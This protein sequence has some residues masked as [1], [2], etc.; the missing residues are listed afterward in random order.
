MKKFNVVLPEVYHQ[1][2]KEVDGINIVEMKQKNVD[3]F[4]TP[5]IERLTKEGGYVKAL[6]VLPNLLSQISKE[7]LN[8]V[9]LFIV[10]NMND[11]EELAQQYHISKKNIYLLAK[12]DLI[13]MQNIVLSIRQRFIERLYDFSYARDKGKWSIHPKVKVS[14]LGDKTHLESSLTQKEI[15]YITYE[16]VEDTHIPLKPEQYYR[17]AVRGRILDAI[18]V[19]IF[20]VTY[21][22]GVKK[23]TYSLE[24]NTDQYIHLS[25][26]VEYG[27]VMIRVQGAGQAYIRNV[28][29][30]AIE[31]NES[32]PKKKNQYLLLT[33]AYASE[34]NLYKNAFIHRR[35]KQYQQEGIELDLFVLNNKNGLVE[36]E[37]DGVKVLQG[38]KEILKNLLSEMK[39]TKI[40]IHF[41]N[42]EMLEAIK[43][44]KI[45]SRLIV[46]IHGFG[47]ERYQ[48]RLYNYS[49]KELLEKR[50]ELEKRDEIQMKV[51]KQ[52]Y[53]SSSVTNIFVSEFIKEIAQQDAGAK[54]K[55]AV[56]I[57]NIID[58]ELFSYKKKPVHQRK[59]ILFIRPFVSHN[60]ACDLAVQVIMELSKRECFNDLSF[61]IYGNGPL[62][63][64]L[65]E[66]LKAFN[67]VSLNP[68]FVKQ[69]EIAMLHK[70]HGI[71]LIPTRHDTQG[72][73]MG[74]AMS[75]GLVVA[76]NK[77]C[78]IP[79]YVDETSGLLAEAEDYIALAN[80][81]EA[82]YYD[83]QRFLELSEN[84]AERVRKQCSKDNTTQREIEIIELL[85]DERY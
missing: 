28:L 44:A 21:K 48:R 74:E 5:Q 64:E 45:E 14:Y 47:A 13:S 60:Y 84:A 79:E 25:K 3:L 11:Y 35:M 83:E 68:I 39:Y 18:D 19:K 22:K 63:E 71:M 81:I 1:F 4:I 51:M 70:K 8:R 9:D 59:R 72:V 53:E 49:E 56:V 46:W 42:Q 15:A 77:V 7:D 27:E 62:Y 57:P 23:D 66:P 55:H 37:F 40:L 76:T 30:D 10:S 33:N 82:I 12:D 41:V 20:F 2:L 32:K 17:L 16:G 75:S 78:A 67:N 36:Y 80:E 34:N 65:T 29:I 58:T 6:Q 26:E 73:S 50:E 52:L 61:S 54:A 69:E 38:N 85:P 31:E 24:I 43:D